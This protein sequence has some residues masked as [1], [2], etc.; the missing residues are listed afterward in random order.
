MAILVTDS[1]TFTSGDFPEIC[2]ISGE[3][4]TTTREVSGDTVR[5]PSFKEILTDPFGTKRRR[6]SKGAVSGSLPFADVVGAGRL[7]AQWHPDV[8]RIVV[9][10]VHPLF[11]EAC[12]EAGKAT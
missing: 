12:R 10:G 1:A 7:V 5:S 3:P 11:V 6:E 9:R 2:A 8:D 4:A